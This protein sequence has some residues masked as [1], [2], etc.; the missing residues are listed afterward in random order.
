MKDKEA[1]H[2]PRPTPPAPFDEPDD[3]LVI[4]E[5]QK[6]AFTRERNGYL[7]LDY[8]G[9]HY[10]RVTLTRL[11]PFESDEEYISVS[12]RKGEDEWRE[13]GVLRAL[14]LLTQA[15]AKTARDYLAY[16]YYIPEITKIRKITDNRMG[17][18]FLDAETSA[19]SKKIAVNDWWHNFR[20]IHGN[21]LS[22]TDADGNRYR[23]S[24]LSKFDRASYA[25]LELFI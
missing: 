2:G 8:D 12:F 14:S 1:M 20:F 24:D 15:Q 21:M 4:L 22:L 13:I 17:Y 10:D 5:P 19:G 3:R 11:V 16:K 25:K 23:I 6:V 7:S 18:L 9:K